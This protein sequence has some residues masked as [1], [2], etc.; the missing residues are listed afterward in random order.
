M[1]VSFNDANILR[2]LSRALPTQPN[3]LCS[4]ARTSILK[5]L[6]CW[7]RLLKSK[8]KSAEIKLDP[9]PFLFQNKTTHEKLFFICFI[10]VIQSFFLAWA[11][12]SWT[13]VLWTLTG[14]W[15]RWRLWILLWRSL[16]IEGR[17]SWCASRIS[18]LIW[19]AFAPLSHQ[20]IHCWAGW[21]V[22]WLLA[23]LVAVL[24][25][26][27]CGWSRLRSLV[28]SGCTLIQVRILLLVLVFALW[29]VLCISLWVVLCIP[30]WVVLLRV[31][32]ILLR[33]LVFLLIA[34]DLIFCVRICR[35]VKHTF[36]FS[37]QIPITKS[38]IT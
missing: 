14:M 12:R 16:R 25:L 4:G 6:T 18:L 3:H 26:V 5:I 34:H 21:C 1:R 36:L 33:S 17:R 28:A 7:D 38:Q 13:K 2:K 19:T 24:A 10:I 35:L 29:L 11:V 15:L 22:V 31:L 9:A 8:K 27:L 23:S 37:K 20:W 32:L 30:L